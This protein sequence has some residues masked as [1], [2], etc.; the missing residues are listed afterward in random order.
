MAQRAEAF[1]SGRFYLPTVELADTSTKF[2]N[3]TPAL[4]NNYDVHINFNTGNTDQNESNQPTLK[5]F[6]NL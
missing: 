5:G 1:R 2:G 6:I 3:I 4:N